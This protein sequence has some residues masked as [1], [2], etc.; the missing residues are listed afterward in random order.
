MGLSQVNISEVFTFSWRRQYQ[1]QYLHKNNAE[2][3]VLGLTCPGN[4]PNPWEHGKI[5][6]VILNTGSFLKI[7]AGRKKKNI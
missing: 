7:S 6:K 2:G 1:E 3:I 4:S 5:Y